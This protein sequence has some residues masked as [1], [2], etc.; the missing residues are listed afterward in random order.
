[1]NDT[2][3]IIGTAGHIDHGKTTLVR[4][5]TGVD[6]DRLDE[7]KRRGITIVLGF[8]PLQL[9]ERTVGVVD[10]PG[11]ERFVRTMVAGAGGVD[12]GL[13]VVAADEGVMPQTREH[14]DVLR[15]LRVPELVVALT[16]TDV[17]DPDLAELA[18]LDV[19]DLLD[20][21]DLPWTD[22]PVLPVSGVTG[23]GVPALRAALEDAIERLPSRPT[24]SV[25][26]M[27]VDRAFTIRG[28]GTVVTGTS[29]D[30]AL[31]GGTTLEILPSRQSVRVRGMQVHGADATHVTAGQR[32]ALNLQGLDAEAV[33]PGSWLATPGALAVSPQVDVQVRLLGDAPLPNNARVRFLSGTAE[34]LATLR[35]VAADGGAA[36]E[37]LEPGTAAF[38]QLALEEPVGAVAGDR[39]VIR[40][41]SP[42]E[43]LGGGVVLDPEPA[44]L[45]RRE[46]PAVARLLSVLADPDASTDDRIAALLRR[47]AGEALDRSALR[48]RLPLHA[49]A[50][51]PA[52]P[53][54][55][56]VRSDPPSWAWSHA[57]DAWV[58]TVRAT[59]A[60]HHAAHPLLDGPLLAEVRQA[61]RPVP[62]ARLFEALLPRLLAVAE[63][64][65]RGP[66]LALRGHDAM[67]TGPVAETLDTFVDRLEA[68]GVHPP[69]LDEATRGLELPPDAL[70]WLIQQG[71]ILRV[72][73]DFYVARGPF[74]ALVGRIGEFVSQNGTMG[75][76]DFKDISGLT[77]RHAMPFLEFLDRERVT[78]RAGNGRTMHPD[79]RH[80]TDATVLASST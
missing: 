60:E 10:V 15:L 53:E 16:R 4:A 46:R 49:G 54:V 47:H 65:L 6:T 19:R 9:G 29:R 78:V 25:F 18:E 39:F 14:L 42:L 70:A 62:E 57:A 33:P 38:A 3:V 7:E 23:D 50:I 40:R 71:R 69:P 58:D 8:A 73:D 13:L 72:A 11:H 12:V 20:A 51:E 66:R 61:L 74:V 63:L 30:G 28:F 77:R 24:S 43:T 79:A 1:M 26:R 22:V 48:R 64:D 44:P 37:E 56:A 2:S 31:R 27:P 21:P 17:A 55:V 36:P 41:E 75:P 34:V 45:R 68:G 5:L 52:H 76:T 80:W 32:V 35:L 59:V 67:P